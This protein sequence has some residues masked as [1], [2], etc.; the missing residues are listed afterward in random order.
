MAGASFEAFFLPRPRG[1]RFCILHTPPASVRAKGAVL[2]VHPFAE[3]MNRTRRAVAVTARALAQDGWTVLLV[4]L[5][6]CGDSSGDFGDATWFEWLDDVSAAY[7]W[8][9]ARHGLPVLWGLRAGGLLVCQAVTRLPE[10]PHLM[11]WQPVVSGKLFL[12]QF[13][14]LKTVA[15]M[16]GEKEEGTSVKAL[17]EALARGESIEIA[18]YALAPSLALPLESAELELPAGYAGRVL[19][20]EVGAEQETALPPA[21]ETRVQRWRERGT[22]VE[23]EVVSGL[24]FWQTLEI[25]ECPGLEHASRGY[26]E[27]L[28]A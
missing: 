22:S 18:G 6:G 24:P 9:K 2:Y 23:A 17:R 19:W 14:R 27:R 21:A 5:L 11:L 4:D 25:A 8:L 13:L 20:A 3:E 15:A 7:D 16:L 10:A 12:N 28:A 26:L 1:A